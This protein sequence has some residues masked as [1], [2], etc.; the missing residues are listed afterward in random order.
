MKTIY[1]YIHNHP[2]GYELED[3]LSYK[4]SKWSTRSKRKG[5][6]IIPHMISIHERDTLYPEIREKTSF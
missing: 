1:N 6:H 4:Q 3:Y 5:K 2:Y